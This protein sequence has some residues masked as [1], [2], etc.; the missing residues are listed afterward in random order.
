MV[1]VTAKALLVN[2]KV[3]VA[4]L[5]A[6]EVFDALFQQ[7]DRVGFVNSIPLQISGIARRD[8][9]FEPYGV[10]IDKIRASSGNTRARFEPDSAG[11]TRHCAN[12]LLIEAD[13]VN[14]AERA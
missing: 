4:E 10:Q 6:V 7:R 9:V 5:A 13:S 8:R 12:Q 11:G 14:L 3:G 1:A 2:E